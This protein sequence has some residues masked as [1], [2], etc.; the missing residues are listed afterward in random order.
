MEPC[1]SGFRI[2]ALAEN[3]ANARAANVVASLGGH[4]TACG[5]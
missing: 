3:G 4:M 1:G 5:K 2:E